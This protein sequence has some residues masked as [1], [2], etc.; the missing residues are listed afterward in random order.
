MPHE[1]ATIDL[2][3]MRRNYE[4][5]EREDLCVPK[6]PCCKMHG[7]FDAGGLPPLFVVVVV[8]CVT[9]PTAAAAPLPRGAWALSDAGRSALLAGPG[10]FQAP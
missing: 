6:Q 9:D 5:G 7:D 3:V 10:G 8:L 2:A 1:P 4:G